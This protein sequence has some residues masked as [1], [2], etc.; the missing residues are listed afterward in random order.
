MKNMRFIGL[1]LALTLPFGGLYGAISAPSQYTGVLGSGVISGPISVSDATASSSTTTGSIITAGGIGVAKDSY[2]GGILTVTESANSRLNLLNGTANTQ[3]RIA[4][5]SASD[6]NSWYVGRETTTNTFKAV[7]GTGL[8]ATTGIQVTTAGLVTLGGTGTTNVHVVNGFI[9]LTSTANTAVLMTAGT[10]DSYTRYGYSGAG[11]SVGIDQTDG[12]FKIDG[13]SG[14]TPSS[15]TPFFTIDTNGL[16]TIGTGT[17]NI[18]RING[19][20]EAAAAGAAT[21]LNA[22]TNA[23][24]NPDIWA[25]ISYNGTTYVFPLWTP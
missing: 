17:S 18:N 5:Q 4:F 11:F 24:G 3:S 10:G 2:I 19:A 16:V 6:T 13:G 8:S 23:G 14:A 21:L 1:Y 9:S 22:P 15:G 7:W 25:K 20:T 12:L